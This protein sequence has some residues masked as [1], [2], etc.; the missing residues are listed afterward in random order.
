MN[1]LIGFLFL[2]FFTSFVYSDNEYYSQNDPIRFMIQPLSRRHNPADQKDVILH[3]TNRKGFPLFKH[4]AIVEKLMERVIFNS[5][6][7]E[8]GDLAHNLIK[9]RYP[10]DDPRQQQIFQAFQDTATIQ[11]GINQVSE[12]KEPLHPLLQIDLMKTVLGSD[13]V[14]QK[15]TINSLAKRQ[16][17]PPELKSVLFYVMMDSHRDPKE[18]ESCWMVLSQINPLIDEHLLSYATVVILSKEIP[19][20][21]RKRI[22]NDLKR[23]NP[24]GGIILNEEY[25]SIYANVDNSAL[26]ENEPLH[27]REA[28]R[29]MVD[30]LFDR[31]RM[32]Q[33]YVMTT[34][35]NVNLHA[36]ENAFSILEKI[37]LPKEGI[38][39]DPP[40][41]EA[42]I[43]ALNY[44]HRPL[45]QKAA[46]AVMQY[47]HVTSSIQQVL[48]QLNLNVEET[49]KGFSLFKIKSVWNGLRRSC[50][51]EFEKKIEGLH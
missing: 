45:I 44:H 9:K 20:S 12:V 27:V 51:R 34:V 40:T 46:L 32:F 26:S 5:N 2:N 33:S 17:L 48:D 28:A 15:V 14:L 38:V 39:P 10:I 22:L 19:D 16:R 29:W 1:V 11:Q 23:M 7:P 41:E 42:L 37:D 4:Q 31:N 21:F 36:R 35:G 47:V 13:E 18:R 49:D 30:N 50:R 8:I 6:S 3:L 25:T 43:R 24:P